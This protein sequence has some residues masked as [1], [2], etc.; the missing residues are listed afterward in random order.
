VLGAAILITGAA[1]SASV[2]RTQTTGDSG[3][4]RVHL[5]G[6]AIGSERYVIRQSEGALALTS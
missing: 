3:K 2:P 4:I 5:L 1:N 6:H